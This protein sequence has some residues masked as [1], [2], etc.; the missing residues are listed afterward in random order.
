MV[1]TA[2][3]KPAM[4]RHRQ[5]K[6]SLFPSCSSFLFANSLSFFSILL[7]GHITSGLDT[8]SKLMIKRSEIFVVVMQ[9]Y[10]S[11]DDCCYFRA[12]WLVRTTFCSFT[13]FWIEAPCSIVI[14]MNGGAVWSCGFPLKHFLRYYHIFFISWSIYGVFWPDVLHFL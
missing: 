9:C 8:L 13:I 5:W 2:C 7:H 4:S 14:T 12:I 1:E 6:S 10:A 11:R 3:Y